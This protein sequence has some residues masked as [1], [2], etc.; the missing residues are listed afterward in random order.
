MHQP[1]LENVFQKTWEEYQKML[2]NKKKG[3]LFKHENYCPVLLKS[4]VHLKK[5]LTVEKTRM[6]Q[7]FLVGVKKYQ[8]L[9]SEFVLFST[10][11]NHTIRGIVLS[12]TVLSGDPPVLLLLTLSMIDNIIHRVRL[13]LRLCLELC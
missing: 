9:V 12:E 11:W 13:L 10:I 3:L 6:R 5:F 2:G 4:L 8:A 1:L 7:I